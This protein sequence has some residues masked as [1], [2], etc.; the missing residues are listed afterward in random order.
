MSQEGTFALNGNLYRWSGGVW[1]DAQTHISPP[2]VTQQELNRRYGHLVG[3]ETAMRKKQK[4]TSKSGTD[5]G[6]QKT[7]GPIMVAFIYSRYA[8][9]QDFVHGDE[10]AAHLLDRPEAVAFLRQVYAQTEQ[11]KSFEDYV[12]NQVSWLGANLDDPNR[13]DYDE[14]VEK[15][16]MADG[17]TGYRPKKWHDFVEGEVY[18]REV[19]VEAIKSWLPETGEQK[20]EGKEAHLTRI[21]Q[22]PER[23]RFTP[24][25]EGWGR[26]PM[27][28]GCWVD[29]VTGEHLG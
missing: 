1:L 8:E 3:V 15:T 23:I 10:I 11:A 21:A 2:S 26:S 27:N 13:P 19:V 24:Q 7:I 4:T 29:A 17:K 28:A 20:R 9:T 14:V 18:N 25:S 16:K 12:A 22:G 6:I 5:K